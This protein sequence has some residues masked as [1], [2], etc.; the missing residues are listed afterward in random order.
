MPLN[1]PKGLP[2]SPGFGARGDVVFG[3]NC[4]CD[5]LFLIP[6]FEQIGGNF[7][8][9]SLFGGRQNEAESCRQIGRIMQ[10]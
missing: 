2:G 5:L 10:R 9:R 4:R 1:G 8:A 7:Q 3:I 6:D